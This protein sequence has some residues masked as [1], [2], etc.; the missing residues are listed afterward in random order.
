MADPFQFAF[1]LVGLVDATA[2]YA[3]LVAR[4]RH[5]RRIEARLQQSAHLYGLVRVA[6]ADRRFA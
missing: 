1:V 3:L 6:V 4:R 2:L 5:E